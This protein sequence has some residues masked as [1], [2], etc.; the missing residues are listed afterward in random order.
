MTTNSQGVALTI[1]N[2]LAGGNNGMNCL[3]ALMNARNFVH[4][5]DSVQFNFSGCREFGKVQISLNG[6]DLYDFIFVRKGRRKF[7]FEV[8]SAVE[9]AMLAETFTRYTGLDVSL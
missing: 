9:A 7:Q 1:V 3:R 8:V 5:K 4:G 6:D 2:Q